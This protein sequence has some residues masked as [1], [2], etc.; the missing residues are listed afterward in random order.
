MTYKNVLTIS[1]DGIGTVG[2]FNS[3]MEF[4]SGNP[5]VFTF[6]I[7]ANGPREDWLSELETAADQYNG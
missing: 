4:R 1:A 5:P 2:V 7:Q 6:E 3:E